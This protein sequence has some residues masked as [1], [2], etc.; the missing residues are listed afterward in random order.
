MSNVNTP[1][2]FIGQLLDSRYRIDEL[3][4]RGG[5]ATV[6]RA[7][8]TRL[9]RTVALK[10]LAGTLAND[11]TFVDRFIHEARSTAAL[12]HPNVV[13]VHDQGIW[14]GF[15]F[16]VMEFVSGQTVREI[17]RQHGPVT[18]AHA[19]EIIKAVLAGLTAAHDAGFVHRDIKP[20][21]VLITSDGHIK[22]TD[23]GLARFINSTGQET[24]TGA[25]L[26]GTM[27]YLSPEQVQQ[28]PI[29]Q[30]SDVYSTGIMLFEL[31]TGQVPFTG[32][33]P[34]DVAFK[35]VQEEVPA[36]STLQPDVPPAVDHIVLAA[37]RKS[38]P[39]RIQSARAF[40]DA[41]CRAM[42]GVGPAEALTTVLPI[43]Q[44]L[45]LPVSS[46]VDKGTGHFTEFDQRSHSVVNNPEQRLP[47][48]SV[49][50]MG[51]RKQRSRL[52]KFTI[53]I[54]VTASLLAGL[55]YYFIASSVTVPSV[56]GMSSGQAVSTL[57]EQDLQPEIVKQ[58]SETVQSGSAIGTRPAQGETV[59]K[60][61]R[62]DVLI[63]KG[64]ERYI[65]PAT[66][67]NQDPNTAT[68]RLRALTLVV[69]NTI[70]T[71]SDTVAIGKVVR[72]V[73]SSGSQVKRATSV[74]L[75]VSKGPAPVNI[76]DVI[77]LTV[78][79]A[80]KKLASAG[81]RTNVQDAK[82]DDSAEGTIIS[83]NPGPGASVKRGSS[84]NI[85]P[86]KGPLLVPVPNVVGMSTDDAV[87]TL[88]A[89]GFKVNKHNR[90]G[91]VVFNSVYSQDPGA[92]TNVRRGSTI[93][94][95]IV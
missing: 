38:V 11:S 84:V 52:R 75:V 63:S 72:T 16:L 74:T 27:A 60:G 22:V 67:V 55:W 54:A 43:G 18:S 26:L 95:E 31:L 82:F 32:S 94:I 41:V 35:H 88:R 61:S 91:V 28:Q 7:T 78:E 92:D 17:L 66:L 70:S 34:L 37:T 62:I 39:D 59:R 15:P 51:P 29:D 57:S 42:T 40:Y 9:G 90:L 5:M 79:Q 13:A 56:A 23:F 50:E 25:V 49:D 44:T 2:P 85:T 46:E 76:P 53:G 45:V 21:N 93:T 68:E 19:L 71:Y 58:F 69:G 73:P 20:E 12:A 4:A 8:D 86:S 48:T 87:A 1:D 33:T 14:N 83:T 30:R 81:L 6:Y 10:I 47:Q 64:K 3:I 65:I 36:P 89:Q 77:G 80:T 24:S